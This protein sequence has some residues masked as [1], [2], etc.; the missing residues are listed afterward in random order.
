MN[1]VFA[2]SIASATVATWPGSVLSSACSLGEP[3]AEPRMKPI[4]SGPR[5]EPPMPSSTTSL[6]CLA[7]WRES[8][9][10][11][12]PSTCSPLAAAS[13]PSHLPSSLPVHIEASC[14]HSLRDQPCL[15]ACSIDCP[16][17]PRRD[18]RAGRRSSRRACR[19]GTWR[20]CR[21]PRR[22][23]SPPHRRSFRRRPSTRLRGDAGQVEPEPVGLAH[24]LLGGIDV[25]GQRLGG[26]AMIAEGVHRLAGGMVLTVSGPISVST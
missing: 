25:G 15:R 5:L 11:L 23:A 14:A 22:R 12:A 4:T 2:G 6:Y 10:S 20:A 18:R 7:S 1:S 8:S 3:E 9:A 21:R 19:P 16:S 17:L 26:V 24:H 13:Q